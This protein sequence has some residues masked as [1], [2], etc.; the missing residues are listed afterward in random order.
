MKKMH[1]CECN[2][3]N[4]KYDSGVLE[5]TTKRQPKKSC[6]GLSAGDTNCKLK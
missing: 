5:N 1:T 2:N 3:S 4:G 6:E